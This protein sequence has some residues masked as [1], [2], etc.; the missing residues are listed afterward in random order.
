MEAVGLRKPRQY[1]VL[2]RYMLWIFLSMIYS[3]SSCPK[4]CYRMNQINPPEQNE[5]HVIPSQI[6]KSPSNNF[7]VQW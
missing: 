5:Q 2:N 6:W 1:G 3:S 7:I 4:T